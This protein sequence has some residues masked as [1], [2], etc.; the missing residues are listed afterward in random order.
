LG[1]GFPE[2]LKGKKKQVKLQREKTHMGKMETMVRTAVATPSLA[3][4]GAG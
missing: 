1:F 4:E 3:H 2:E